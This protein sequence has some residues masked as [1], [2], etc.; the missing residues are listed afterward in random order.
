M[1][2]TLSVSGELEKLVKKHP[3]IKWTEFARQGMLNEAVGI[4]KT[5]ILRKVIEKKDITKEDM[6]WMDNNDWHPVDEMGLK[7]SFIND[8]FRIS[9]KGKFRKVERLSDILG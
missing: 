5:E 3:E 6:E 7:S 9:K 2:L 8:S 1:N 4:K